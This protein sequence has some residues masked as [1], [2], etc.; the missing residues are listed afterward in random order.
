MNEKLNSTNKIVLLTLGEST[1]GK[2]SFIKKY[3][4]NE[5]NEK[6]MSTVGMDFYTKYLTFSENEKNKINYL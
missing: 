2:T 1:V 3:V 6:I 4:K 5:F